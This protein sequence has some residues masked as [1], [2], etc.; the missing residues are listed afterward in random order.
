MDS[1]DRWMTPDQE[2]GFRDASRLFLRRMILV[3]RD[4]TLPALAADV[5]GRRRP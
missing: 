5:R 4:A 3:E 2:N 1:T